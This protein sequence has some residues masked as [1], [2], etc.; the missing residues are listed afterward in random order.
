MTIKIDK[1]AQASSTPSTERTSFTPRAPAPAPVRNGAAGSSFDGGLR[2]PKKVNLSGAGRRVDPSL[3]AEMIGTSRAVRGQG[4]LDP[5]A[6]AT[7]VSRPMA[8]A[9]GGQDPL[10]RL[11]D[12][13]WLNP[14]QLEAILS[15]QVR[16]GPLSA[17][18]QAQVG[19]LL[20]EK[21]L[22]APDGGHTLARFGEMGLYPNVAR[23]V[24]R[25]FDAGALTDAH[26]A[27]LLDP[28]R[29]GP[30]SRRGYDFNGIAS[31]VA[32]SGSRGLQSATAT[33]I[34]DVAARQPD[35]HAAMEF[36][37]AAMRATGGS[38]QATQALLQR[39]GPEAM[40]AAVDTVAYASTHSPV[41]PRTSRY[42]NALGSLLTGL[43]G[44]PS[45]QS[46]NAVGARVVG[47]LTEG[48][49]EAPALKE[50]FF[51]YLRSA[52]GSQSWRGLG[53]A[54]GTGFTERELLTK[55]R[56]PAI[57][58]HMVTEQYYRVSQATQELLP[59]HANWATFAVWAS[60]QAGS[61][62]RGEPLMG[63]S[64]LNG[65]VARSLSHGNTLVA[66]E[67]APLFGAFAQTLKNNPNATFQ[68]VWRAA[69]SPN[70]TPLLREAFQN[71]YD[72]YQ[73]RNSGG[74]ADA[75][76]EKMLVA[77]ALV[78]QHE[79]AALQ[80]DIDSSMRVLGVPL[81]WVMAGTLNLEL[82]GRTLHLNHDLTG[83]FPPELREL[84]NPRARQLAQQFGGP[85][86]SG[87]R[88]WPDYQQ[89]MEYIFNLFRLN[90]RDRALFGEWI[91]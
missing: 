53:P 45:A 8:D 37:T 20:V 91:R 81:A 19:R 47:H 6:A 5:S 42:A 77:N 62:I 83:Q 24:G 31:L 82:P 78:G 80:A 32:A 9:A 67:I 41:N 25:A 30:L 79:Q 64:E 87:T 61:A 16:P 55:F 21:H 1:S 27:Q 35:R 14:G 22:A 18:D 50:G 51:D 73:L 74:S 38:P 76:A 36:Q 44:L 49:L 86:G 10:R 26:L 58:N 17:A 85:R 4:S 39:A 66:A 88:N 40:A 69:G 70:N 68:D 90:Q 46:T 63:L 29:G 7:A 59:G 2:K 54:S 43:S 23:S 48:H 65:D 11:V 15:G 56:D 71:Y 12:Q 28:R 13:H 3:L 33:R 34:W 52:R 75:I 72:A 84:S 60:R 89:R 57:R